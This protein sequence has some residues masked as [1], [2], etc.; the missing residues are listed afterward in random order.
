LLGF[1]LVGYDTD[2]FYSYLY[3]YNDLGFEVFDFDHNFL[4]DFH[5]SP[6]LHPQKAQLHLQVTPFGLALV[7]VVGC[8]LFLVLLSSPHYAVALQM[9]YLEMILWAFPHLFWNI[10]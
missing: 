10:R 4:F 9:P 8:F 3:Y 5:L 7:V 2:R 1:L 6:L